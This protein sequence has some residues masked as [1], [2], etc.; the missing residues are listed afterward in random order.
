MNSERASVTTPSPK[1][2]I[3]CVTVTMPPS[4]NAWRIFPREPTM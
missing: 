2:P 1:T 4:A 3:V